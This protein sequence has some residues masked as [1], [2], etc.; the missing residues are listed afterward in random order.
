MTGYLV[1]ESVGLMLA[2]ASAPVAATH[3]VASVEATAQGTAKSAVTPIRARTRDE[4]IGAVALRGFPSPSN[5]TPPAITWGDAAQGPVIEVGALGARRPNVP[6]LAHLSL[7][8]Q[9]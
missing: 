8:W 3:T 1:F 6:G 2:A 7:D 9:F 5:F 4:R